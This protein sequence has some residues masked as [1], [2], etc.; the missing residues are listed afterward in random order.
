MKLSEMKKGQ[1]GQVQSISGNNPIVQRLY[2]MGIIPG[3]SIQVLRFAPLGDPMSIRI[4]NTQL[5]LRK[6]EASLIEM[7]PN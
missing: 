2:E 6:T 4:Q 5:A 7:L 3:I 1:F